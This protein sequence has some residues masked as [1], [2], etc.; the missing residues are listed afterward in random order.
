MP[1]GPSAWAV[2]VPAAV[3]GAAL[4][5]LAS[6]AQAHATQ[7][8]ETARTLDPALLSRLARRPLWLAGMPATVAGLVLQLVALAFAPLLVV[9]PCW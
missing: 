6:A 1:T 5:G 4:T 9:Q 2:A 8:V 3:A 7:Q